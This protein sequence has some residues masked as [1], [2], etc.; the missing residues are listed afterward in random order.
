[1]RIPWGWFRLP[2]PPP[3]SHGDDAEAEKDMAHR[4]TVQR[5]DEQTERMRRWVDVVDH[6]AGTTPREDDRR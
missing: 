6:I 3:N 1:M 2:P 4:Q 5:L